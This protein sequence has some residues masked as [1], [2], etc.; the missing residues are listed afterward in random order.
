LAFIVVVE[1]L[2]DIEAE[3]VGA[4]SNLE[5][6]WPGYNRPVFVELLFPVGILIKS[7]KETA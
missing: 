5:V 3:V 1:F 4:N 6:L 2:G 7:L